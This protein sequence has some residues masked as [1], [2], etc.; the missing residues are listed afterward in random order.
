M[1]LRRPS[2]MSM[3]SSCRTPSTPPLRRNVSSSSASV[4]LFAFSWLFT[5]SEREVTSSASFPHGGQP[6][7]SASSMTRGGNDEKG[8]RLLQS[9]EE[10]LREAA[11]AVGHDALGQSHG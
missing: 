5:A 11:Q 4:S 8:I 9:E 1:R 7:L 2:R 6:G 10:S 3:R